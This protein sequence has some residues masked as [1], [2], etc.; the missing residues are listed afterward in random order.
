[1]RNV[2]VSS[3][4]AFSGSALRRG[5]LWLPYLL[6]NDP[7]VVRPRHFTVF[8]YPPRL[9]ALVYNAITRSMRNEIV[10][11]YDN[12]ACRMVMI[13][14][15]NERLGVCLRPTSDLLGC[16]TKLAAFP[17]GKREPHAVSTCRYSTAPCDGYA[18]P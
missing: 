18:R 16:R 1:M 9:P 7:V 11:I 6:F 15:A 13:F 17:S 2:T 12:N 14:T 3:P 10:P 5:T 4:A 8:G